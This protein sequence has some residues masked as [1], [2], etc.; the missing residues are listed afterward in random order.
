M[1]VTP[2]PGQND[3]D[4]HGAELPDPFVVSLRN[5][6]TKELREAISGALT[7]PVEKDS[8]HVRIRRSIRDYVEM[9]KVV[10]QMEL[11][12]RGSRRQKVSATVCN[13]GVVTVCNG[14]VAAMCDGDVAAC[15]I[16]GNG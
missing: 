8:N 12:A 6:A 16:T 4:S 11:A 13:G 7:C 14:G 10:I 9:E 3:D 15:G 5:P 1:T 2:R